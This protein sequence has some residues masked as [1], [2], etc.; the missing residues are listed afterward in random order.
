MERW[1]T[2]RGSENL[3]APKPHPPTPT[4]GEEKG[5]KACWPTLGMLLI[6]LDESSATTSPKRADVISK[7]FGRCLKGTPPQKES[8]CC[9]V[10]YSEKPLSISVGHLPKQK[11]H[12]IKMPLKKMPL[13]QTPTSP[14]PRAAPTPTPRFGLKA[15]GGA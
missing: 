10:P 3:M 8:T 11:D 9:L 15:A 12:I 13:T 7:P 4:P 6:S 1:L 5:K 14:A 2:P